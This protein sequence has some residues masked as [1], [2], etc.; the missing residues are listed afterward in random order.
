MRAAMSTL[1]DGYQS[2]SARKRDGGRRVLRPRDIRDQEQTI[3]CFPERSK[4]RTMVGSIEACHTYPSSPLRLDL[5]AMRSSVFPFHV[6]IYI[7]IYISLLLLLFASS[8]Y[9]AGVAQQATHS[10]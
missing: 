9:F 5:Q 1:E 2:V 4:L 3:V 6:Y 7:Y 10:D 8:E